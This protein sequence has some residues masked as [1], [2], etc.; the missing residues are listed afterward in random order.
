MAEP[1][2]TF[3]QKHPGFD[4]Y[5]LFWLIL[6]L[7]LAALGRFYLPLFIPALV[8]LIYLIFRLS[9]KNRDKRE[10]ENARFLALIRSIVRWFKGRKKGLK[11]THDATYLYFKCP[12]CGQP[13]RVPK[14]LGKVQIHCRSCGSQFETKS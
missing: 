5:S 1:K 13:M 12:T 3:W 14:G 10:I 6:F 7:I 4:L 9:S 2:Q 11:K 8:V